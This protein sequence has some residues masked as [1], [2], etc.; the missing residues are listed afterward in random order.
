MDATDLSVRVDESTRRRLV[1]IERTSLVV[2]VPVSYRSK[3]MGDTAATS[4]T[5][6]VGSSITGLSVRLDGFVQKYQRKAIRVSSVGL[7]VGYQ[8]KAIG[9][10]SSRRPGP[11][12]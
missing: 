2:I 11:R 5:A 12:Q 7:S 9:R 6:E 8:H 1:A 3:A 4:L 10:A